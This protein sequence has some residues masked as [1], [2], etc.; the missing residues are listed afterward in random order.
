MN[1]IIFS[2]TILAVY[3]IINLAYKELKKIEIELQKE[4]EELDKAIEKRT[5]IIEKFT[6][7]N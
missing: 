6:E 4:Q 2:L 1:I 7:E 3:G 5:E